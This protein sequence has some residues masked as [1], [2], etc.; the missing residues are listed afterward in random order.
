M[1]TAGFSYEADIAPLR[2]Q[3]FGATSATG[4]ERERQLDRQAALRIA[5]IQEAGRNRELAFQQ[6]QL[7]LQRRAED[8]RRMREAM[9][10]IPEVTRTLTSIM[11]DPTKS[12]TD[13]AAEIARYRMQMADPATLNPTISNLF[14]TSENTIKSRREQQNQTN[15]LAY[16]LAQAGRTDAVRKLYEKSDNP[17]AAQYIAAADAIAAERASEQEQRGQYETAKAQQEQAESLRKSQESYLTGYMDTLRR[18]SPP[19]VKGMEDTDVGTL[20]RDGSVKPKTGA[21]LPEATLN[22]AP[23]DRIELEEMFRDLNPAYENEKL[24]KAQFTDERL[25]RLTLQSV[26][27]K[28]RPLRGIK[29]GLDA[30][31]FRRSP[32]PESE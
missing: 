9:T 19:T 32:S 7:E 25:Y 6:Q 20:R 31:K 30:S 21:K 22:F 4:L 28:L 1:A 16:T 15:A 29:T 17:M 10:K 24:D 2:G 23:E 12:D 14:Q 26:Q 27:S 11:E 8:D 3:M 18:L 5:E 13:K